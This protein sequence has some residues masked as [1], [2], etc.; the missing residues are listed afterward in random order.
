MR[1]VGVWLRIQCGAE[2]CSKGFVKLIISLPSL[3]AWQLL[4]YSPINCL[5]DPQ[6]TF[7]K[8]SGGKVGAPD[9]IRKVVWQVRIG[10]APDMHQPYS[11]LSSNSGRNLSRCYP[12]RGPC[13]YMT[14]AI[15]GAGSWGPQKVDEVRELVRILNC[16]VYVSVTIAERGVGEGSKIPK[17][18][19][20]SCK[21]RPVMVLV[22]L[23][24]AL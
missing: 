2:N 5:G 18:L 9:S 13:L 10:P 7:Y 11:Y 23:A 1:R 3:H 6:K 24:A 19:R 17:V 12:R 8:T 14:S 22:F 21:Y 16:A 20:T 4:Q 15:G